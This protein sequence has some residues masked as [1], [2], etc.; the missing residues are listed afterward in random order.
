MNCATTSSNLDKFY[1]TYDYISR[2]N[3]IELCGPKSVFALAHNYKGNRHWFAPTY[4]DL[5]HVVESGIWGDSANGQPVSAGLVDKYGYEA[6]RSG[7][8]LSASTPNQLF[9]TTEFRPGLGSKNPCPVMFTPV[10]DAV[11]PSQC[12]IG[13]TGSPSCITT[14]RA[15][16]RPI[17]PFGFTQTYSCANSG[18]CVNGDLTDKGS[19]AFGSAFSAPQSSSA[20]QSA[21]LFKV[22]ADSTLEADSLRLTNW[23][24]AMPTVFSSDPS[25]TSR[26]GSGPTN[27]QFLSDSG[28]G[29]HL[30]CGVMNTQLDLF[31]IGLNIDGSSFVP[32]KDELADICTVAHRTPV[33]NRLF[34]DGGSGGNKFYDFCGLSL[35]AVH[36]SVKA[37]GTHTSA[38]GL[39]SSSPVTASRTNAWAWSFSENRMISVP[40]TSDNYAVLT[41]IR[42]SDQHLLLLPRSLPY[43][44]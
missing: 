1:G 36:N 35:G 21:S 39:W 17:H 30:P 41:V 25:W 32:S 18:P 42:Q 2:Y 16:T 7:S 6:I 34:P 37:D 44:K 40:I 22:I 8:A 27:G 15:F 10:D 11:F 3:Q 13:T 14:L 43:G 4:D 28:T 19:I 38:L 29:D 23:C 31:E 12:P 26:I 24:N 9:W 5:G 20:P 33:N